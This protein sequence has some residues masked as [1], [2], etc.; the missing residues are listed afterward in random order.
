VWGAGGTSAEQQVIVPAV[1][2]V[3][4]YVAS[5]VSV[6]ALLSAA[7]FSAVTALGITELRARS[8]AGC[9]TP[10]L[11]QVMVGP[12]NIHSAGLGVV[13]DVP[14]FAKRMRINVFWASPATPGTP[15]KLVEI[16]GPGG[17]GD[18]VYGALV[19]ERQVVDY[20]QLENLDP[21]TTQV[22]LLSTGADVANAHVIFE[23]ET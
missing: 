6:E 3:H 7:D 13:V 20:A 10:H 22:R 2:A 19:V 21:G 14:A 12:I 17:I 5:A 15:Y 11:R 9:G 23:V 4:H 16:N 8:W 1:G 18:S